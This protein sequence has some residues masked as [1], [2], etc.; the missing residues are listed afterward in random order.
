MTQS[1]QFVDEAIVT[2][3]AGDGGDGLASFRRAKFVP[4]GGPNGGDGGRGGSVVFVA[5]RNL[6]TLRDQK[7]RREI[8]AASGEP[9]GV[10]NRFGAGGSD[11]IVRVPIGTVLYDLAEDGEILHDLA[12]DG[13]RFIVATGG[14]GG[15]GNTRFKTS[16]RQA[17]DFFTRGMPGQ[18][19]KLRLSLK[20]LADVGLVGLPNA[21]K[22]TLLARISAAR[23]RVADYPF[24]TL[25]PNLGV[26]EIDHRSFVVAD[27][28]GL[29]EGASE[30]VGLGDRFLRHVERTRVL[31]HLLD[32][33]ALLDDSRD[34]LGE[35]DTIRAEIEAYGEELGERREIILLNKTDLS[36]DAVAFD[37][38]E[39][40]L[41]ER[42]LEVLRGSG[43]TG[44]GIAVLIRAMIAAIDAVDAE[45]VSAAGDTEATT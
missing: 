43:V 37:E 42:G 14:K 15:Q 45:E 35:Y 39:K 33:A 3:L 26:A 44:N 31:V 5:D 1:E 38:I 8:R 18:R 20:L 23:P 22:S 2:A 24:T 41:Q 6:G 17:P 40:A 30:G 11:T 10:N 21:G 12:E 13:E 34:L 36:P 25:T 28:P 4:R 9:G 19:R 7:Y 16:T 27:I 29:I 32:G